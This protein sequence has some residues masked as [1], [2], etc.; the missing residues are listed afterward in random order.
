MSEGI[1]FPTNLLKLYCHL[2]FQLV[3]L[4]TL[5][6][7]Q[8]RGRDYP[9]LS[10]SIG[11]IVFFIVLW[12]YSIVCASSI[13]GAWPRVSQTLGFLCIIPFRMFWLQL[14]PVQSARPGSSGHAVSR[15]WV[16]TDCHC[17]FHCHCH[18]G[19]REMSGDIATEC[20]LDPG[21]D[22]TGSCKNN[23]LQT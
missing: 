19:G 3:C 14:L 20:Q 5:Y 11:A 21:T 7:L 16:L 12:S 8:K 18:P 2:I 1:T 23:S 9:L 15:L 6:S 13:I 22:Y 10:L 4:L 17:H